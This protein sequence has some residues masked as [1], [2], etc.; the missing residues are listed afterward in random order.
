MPRDRRAPVVAGNHRRLFAERTDEADHVADQVQERV[1][2]DLRRRV[3][4]AVTAHVRRHR[5]KAGGGERREL[6]TPGVPGFGKAVTHD[7]ERA[8][9]LFGHVHANSVRLDGAVRDLAH[10]DALAMTAITF[11]TSSGS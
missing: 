6:M 9:A 4:L 1:G 10:A 11:C 2:L 3:G 8:G 7:H 5:V